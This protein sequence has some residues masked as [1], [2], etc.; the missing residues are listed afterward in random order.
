MVLG[1][2]KIFSVYSNHHDDSSDGTESRR[3][4]RNHGRQEV[5]TAGVGVRRGGAV[6]QP[7]YGE[8]ICPEQSD[9]NSIPTGTGDGKDVPDHE[10]VGGEIGASRSM[11]TGQKQRLLGGINKTKTLWEKWYETTKEEEKLQNNKDVTAQCIDFCKFT[12]SVV[13]AV[14][15]HAPADLRGGT[16]L[17]HLRVL[18]A[19]VACQENPHLCLQIL[20]AAKFQVFRGAY[21]LLRLLADTKSQEAQA[22][23]EEIRRQSSVSVLSGPAIVITNV[24]TASVFLAKG[25]STKSVSRV[26]RT[27]RTAQKN[28]ERNAPSMHTTVTYMTM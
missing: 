2:T 23:L 26:V 17:Q 21:I 3:Q 24:A 27:A 11:K 10:S 20:H 5:H 13:H 7:G 9:R 1:F 4:G 22:L 6:F 25:W 14:L 12:T 28:M 16:L 18:V 15:R 19:T 8:T